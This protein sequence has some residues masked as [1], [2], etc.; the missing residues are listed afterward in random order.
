[1]K[2]NQSYSGS[3]SNSFVREGEK[4]DSNDREKRLIYDV[5]NEKDIYEEKPSRR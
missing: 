1:M 5:D 2:L 3:L 4:N